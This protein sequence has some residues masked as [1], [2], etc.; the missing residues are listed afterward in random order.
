MLHEVSE[1]GQV[2]AEA[3]LRVDSLMVVDH[4][5]CLSPDD[6]TDGLILVGSRICGDLPEEKHGEDVMATVALLE[7]TKGSRERIE[8]VVSFGGFALDL[9]ELELECRTLGGDLSLEVRALP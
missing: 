6:T 2:V 7:E 3:V 1:R 4:P 9:V 5:E 8:L